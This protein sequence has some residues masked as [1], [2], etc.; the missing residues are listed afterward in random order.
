MCG[1]TIPVTAIP[2]KDQVPAEKLGG[3][4]TFPT[5]WPFSQAARATSEQHGPATMEDMKPQVSRKPAPP[6][7][8]G[9]SLAVLRQ[10]RKKTLGAHYVALEAPD[11]RIHSTRR[12]AATQPSNGS[13]TAHTMRPESHSGVPIRGPA[14]SRVP[15][16]LAMRHAYLSQRTMQESASNVS[17]DTV[18]K[19]SV[20]LPESSL[21]GRPS[22]TAAPPALRTTGKGA[23]PA[24]AKSVASHRSGAQSTIRRPSAPPR[25]PQRRPQSTRARIG[26][27][28]SAASKVSDRVTLVSDDDTE[29]D[30]SEA[31]EVDPAGAGH[32][33]KQGHTGDIQ[34][35]CFCP[36]SMVASGG[37]DGL[38]FVWSVDT[39]TPLNEFRWTDS[40]AAKLVQS[41][42]GSGRDP[43]STLGRTAVPKKLCHALE[44][45]GATCDSICF[46]RH[47]VSVAVGYSNGWVSHAACITGVRANFGCCAFVQVVFWHIFS[48]VCVLSVDTTTAQ[49]LRSPPSLVKPN[50]EYGKFGVCAVSVSEKKGDAKIL[51]V[52]TSHGFV[53]V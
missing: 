44:D 18:G 30:N 1:W 51:A 41:S 12:N 35:L 49:V 34:C 24:M 37:S 9:R 13:L 28:G 20:S 36:P 32:R 21:A 7:R 17:L 46:C 48:A 19:P 29:G 53:Q 8:R 15:R 14:D 11:A 25:T 33:L 42:R 27:F 43:T 52:G 40:A 26:L 50:R 39:G 16:A 6:T 47:L 2:F 23:N 22:T 5:T 4:R 31:D 45:R 3:V 38:V 10:M